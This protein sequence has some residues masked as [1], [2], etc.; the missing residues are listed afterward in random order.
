MPGRVRAS[1]LTARVAEILSDAAGRKVSNA[2]IARQMGV[3][4][5][6]VGRYMNGTKSP[7][8]EEF[9]TICR[10]IGLDPMDVLKQAEATTGHPDQ[11][12]ALRVIADE[13]T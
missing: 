10:I 8:L 2:E 1:S 9:D 7:N 12:V 13:T 6:Q 5:H 3:S 11:D 4:P